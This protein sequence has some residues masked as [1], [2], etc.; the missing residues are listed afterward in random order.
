MGVFPALGKLNFDYEIGRPPP[1]FSR[2]YS[3]VNLRKRNGHRK[4]VLVCD[5]LHEKGHLLE[6]IFALNE[7]NNVYLQHNVDS[8]LIVS[9][10]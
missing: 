3:R 4:D 1:D 7:K 8:D 9:G 6:T 10:N 2:Q 5:A